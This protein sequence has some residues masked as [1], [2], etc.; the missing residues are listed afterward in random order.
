MLQCLQVVRCVCTFT[1]DWRNTHT[2][3]PHACPCRRPH[4]SR[5]QKRDLPPCVHSRLHAWLSSP[6]RAARR[7]HTSVAVSG[8]HDMTGSNPTRL[9]SLAHQEV[10]NANKC[11]ATVSVLR[12]A[13][14]RSCSC[15]R[16]ACS[17][18]A[19]FRMLQQLPIKFPPPPTACAFRVV[20]RSATPVHAFANL[21]HAQIRLNVKDLAV[22]EAAQRPTAARQVAAE[23]VETRIMATLSSAYRQQKDPAARRGQ[24]KAAQLQRNDSSAGVATKSSPRRPDGECRLR[25]EAA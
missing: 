19:H 23:A 9:V 17:K 4:P 22:C 8:N 24:T 2:L 21:A 10:Q 6:R 3:S 16:C 5:H 13:L 1:T 15:A 18:G 20:L 25:K 11:I 12:I 14:A 7:I